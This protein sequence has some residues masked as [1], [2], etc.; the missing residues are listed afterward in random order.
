MLDHTV[1]KALDEISD[2]IEGHFDG[3]VLGFHGSISLIWL[4]EF[5]DNLEKLAKRKPKKDRLILVLTTDGGSAE[6]TEEMADYMRHHYKEIYF[7][8]PDRAM[9]AGTI[10]CMAGD[11][12]YMDY[13]SSLGP[14]DPQIPVTSNS[15]VQFVPALGYLDKYS[16]LIEKSA[17]NTITPAE[18]QMVLN[19]DLATL[20]QYEQA[21]DLSVELLK[22]WL[23]Q[24]KFK[25]WKTHKTDP[26]KKGTE[27]TVAE[28]KIRAEEIAILLSNNK[29]W[30][31]HGR[32]INI[33]TARNELRLV[34]DDY[35]DEPDLQKQIRIYN[36]LV[37][38]YVERQRYPVFIHTRSIEGTA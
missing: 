8:I 25:N 12:I 18:F 27:V 28:K 5:R 17:N 31:S 14:I 36:D 1:R 11:K 35:G 4:K 24:Y 20:Q 3:D 30:H 37:E 15:G 19:T 2:K 6:A 21:R 7:L 34:I 9:S 33:D 23:V 22:K 38:D 16:A 26:D 10:L 32:R 13:T 29:K